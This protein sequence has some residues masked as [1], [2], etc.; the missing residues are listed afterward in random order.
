M[1]Q[2][3]PT[4]T[5]LAV[6][7]ARKL[8][9]EQNRIKAQQEEEARSKILPRPWVKFADP[10]PGDLTVRVMSWNLLAQCL[11]RRALFPASDCLK[12]AQRENMLYREILSHN[13]D[14]CCMQEVDRTEKL[15]PVL[16]EAGY[17]LNYATGPRKHHGCLIAYKK[18]IFEQIQERKIQYDLQEVHE[19]G[20]ERAR[21]GS[22]FVTRNIAF[23][24]ALRRSKGEDD[25]II[26][27]TTHLFWHP[28]QVTILLREVSAFR[29]QHGLD[30][31][32]CIIAG[33][34][35]FH[36]SDSVYSLIVGDPL[37]PHQLERLA[38]SRVVH[39]TID[40]EVPIT[41]PK[42]VVED[43]EDGDESDPDRIITNSRLATEADGLL[44]DEELVQMIKDIGS[45][46][47]VYDQGLRNDHN[48]EDLPLT[49]GTHS[50]I[51]QGRLGGF[52]PNFTSYTHYWKCT[53]DYIFVL[54][55]PDRKVGIL[56]IAKPHP[57][58]SLE[59]GLPHYGIGGS[60]HIS[61]AADLAW[62]SISQPSH[63]LK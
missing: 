60:D 51:P 47:S 4:P 11:I 44:T 36:P 37:L 12:A 49:H 39:V 9:K 56:G 59:P 27:A 57:A 43:D 55:P 6:A 42:L 23:M 28:A 54:D 32:P 15:F 7:E 38:T 45:P 20:T 52:E 30:H 53:L 31:W 13:A 18:D 41:S 19:E 16:E 17:A 22:S 5:E 2:R 25:G 26:I 29:K 34:F 35:N 46:I 58:A 21:R 10:N 33:D 48:P 50:P 14:V 3:Q 61:L 8:K 62:S 24:L 1:A 63:N 40:P